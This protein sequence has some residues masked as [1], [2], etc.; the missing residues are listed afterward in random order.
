LIEVI[1]GELYALDCVGF[2][3]KDAA[4]RGRPK[5]G[6]NWLSFSGSGV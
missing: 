3:Q 4:K 1:G 5:K 6:V 2:G